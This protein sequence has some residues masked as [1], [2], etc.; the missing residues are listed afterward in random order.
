MSK[1]DF[2]V[3][4]AVAQ[5]PLNVFPIFDLGNIPWSHFEKEDLARFTIEF[6][7]HSSMIVI[8]FAFLSDPDS[9]FGV[10]LEQ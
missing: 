8:I 7:H 9:E 6:Q 2:L 3:E 4:F 5:L 1:S 10:G